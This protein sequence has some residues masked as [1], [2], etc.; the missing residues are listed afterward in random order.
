MPLLHMQTTDKKS[1][2]D[3]NDKMMTFLPVR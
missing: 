2:L 3:Y 1:S